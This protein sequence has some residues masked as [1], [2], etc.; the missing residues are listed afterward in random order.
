MSDGVSRGD[1]IAGF[2]YESKNIKRGK[3]WGVAHGAHPSLDHVALDAHVQERRM[4]V[5]SAV[6]VQ[7]Q[8]RKSSFLALLPRVAAT[9]QR[10]MR[11]RPVHVFSGFFGSRYFTATLP[12]PLRA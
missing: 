6:R 10:G 8:I 5:T 1:P 2:P 7:A 12:L 3:R 11:P 9:I 4:E